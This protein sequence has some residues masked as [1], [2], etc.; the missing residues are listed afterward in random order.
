MVYIGVTCVTAKE[1]TDVFT[2]S[3]QNVARRR[4]VMFR[5]WRLRIPPGVVISILRATKR[6]VLLAGALIVVAI[7]VRERMKTAFVLCNDC[8]FPKEGVTLVCFTLAWMTWCRGR[9]GC[10]CWCWGRRGRSAG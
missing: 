10:G 9:G 7:L 3:A 6:I 5:C 4:D 1:C 2:A 8:A